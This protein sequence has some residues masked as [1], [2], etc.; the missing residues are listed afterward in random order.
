M[1]T[2]LARPELRSTP[3]LD[4]RRSRLRWA[5]ALTLLASG[6]THVPIIPEHL[7]EAPYVG[8]LFIVLTVACALLAVGLLV[9]DSMALWALSALTCGLSVIAFVWSRTLGLPQIGDDIGNWL[10]PL[11]IAAVLAECLTVAIAFA[12]LTA[13]GESPA[14]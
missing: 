13:H 8:V 6:A 3:V 4:G 7:K 12:A 5:A 10:E 2:R 1:A 14:S 11:G 9:S